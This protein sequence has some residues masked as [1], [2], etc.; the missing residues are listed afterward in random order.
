MTPN[1]L[2]LVAAGGVLAGAA[3]NGPYDRMARELG[4]AARAGG[5]R[6]VAVE[7]FTAVAGGDEAGGR[8][9]AERLASRLAGAGGL[10]VV[11]RAR[12]AAP[13]DDRAR[14]V[15]KRLDP[16]A[17]RLFFAE[18][19]DQL[20]CID[21]EACNTPAYREERARLEGDLHARI[22]AVMDLVD[23]GQSLPDVD[24]VVTGAFVALDGG[25]VEV[26]ARLISIGTARLLG[27]VTVP[28]DRDWGT[29]PAP[30]RPGGLAGVAGAV[31]A[32]AFG[33]WAVGRA[34]RAL[35]G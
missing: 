12:L 17:E 28:V 31:G 15:L 35:A 9:L 18:V 26:H 32:A 14:A 1:L 4:D 20:R 5:A 22:Q 27:A 34:A 19:L 11:D 24:A 30:A 33:L 29:P 7:P 3:G 6:K 16:A 23:R 13:L 10:E 8:V 25:R 2:L 21:L